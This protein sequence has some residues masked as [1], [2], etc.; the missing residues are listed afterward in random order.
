MINTEILATALWKGMRIKE[1][2]VSHYPRVAGEQ[3]GANLKVILKALGELVRMRS[4][5]RLTGRAKKQL[6]KASYVTE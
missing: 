5:L 1:I 4:K 6:A 2:P 3:S